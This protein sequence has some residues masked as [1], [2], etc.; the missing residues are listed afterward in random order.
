MEEKD[1]ERLLAKFDQSSLQEFEMTQGD[2]HLAFSKRAQAAPVVANSPASP[3]AAAAAPAP[4]DPASTADKAAPA[5]GQPA[6]PAADGTPVTAP[7]VGVA[8]FAAAPD[9]PPFKQIGDHV[10]KGETIFVIEAM[11][12][13]NEVPSPLSGTLRKQLVKDGTMVEY[14]EPVVV[15][16]PDGD[17]Q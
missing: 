1:I 17:G 8:Y 2:L 4:A 12:M 13:I 14:D 11:K 15:I 9:K 6:A 5:D 16:E 3:A 7:L 10:D